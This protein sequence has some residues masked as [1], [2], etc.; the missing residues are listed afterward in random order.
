VLPGRVVAVVVLPGRVVA[1][2]VVPGRV[3]VV[4][5]DGGRGCRW[6]SCAP[7]EFDPE[8]TAAVE[9]PTIINA[10]TDKT[11]TIFDLGIVGM[12]THI[13]RR[14]RNR[15]ITYATRF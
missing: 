5:V 12:L 4:V 9:K 2:V 13:C 15:P 7:V 10:S 8:A 11:P 6:R 3:V 1:V 14:V